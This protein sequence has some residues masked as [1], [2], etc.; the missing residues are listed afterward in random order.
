[1]EYYK[2]MTAD[3]FCNY[4]IFEQKLKMTQLNDF[5]DAYEPEILLSDTEIKTHIKKYFLE[6]APTFLYGVESKIIS[7]LLR[8]MIFEENSFLYKS[9][10]NKEKR[11]NNTTYTNLL[12]QINNKLNDVQSIIKE[13][14]KYA[15]SNYE[16]LCLSKY[17]N[18]QIMYD[19]Y[20][21]HKGVMLEF[22]DKFISNNRN[23]IY[24]ENK[25]KEYFLKELKN[26]MKCASTNSTTKIKEMSNIIANSFCFKNTDYSHE[27]ETRIMYLKEEFKISPNLSINENNTYLIDIGLPKSIT[28]G[29]NFNKHKNY[30]IYFEAIKSFCIKN[31]I[32]LYQ[33]VKSL[34]TDKQ[35]NRELI[36]LK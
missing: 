36:S 9:G 14:I 22:N 18:S 20:G 7:I 3:S 2:Y 21:E 26:F 13:A 27:Y 33:A 30:K 34:E 35:M 4:F 8:K 29:Y 1:M 10:K 25:R 17:P 19:K 6:L 28:L 23:V 5:T 32:E 11:K 31:N 24:G 15:S 16:V 12:I